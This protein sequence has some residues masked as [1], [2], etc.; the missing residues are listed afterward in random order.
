VYVNVSE[1]GELSSLY[2]GWLQ[3]WLTAADGDDDDDGGG[4]GDVKDIHRGPNI[5]F[6]HAVLALVSLPI[7]TVSTCTYVYFY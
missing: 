4:G 2:E 3:S 5:S 1:N 7:L 6:S